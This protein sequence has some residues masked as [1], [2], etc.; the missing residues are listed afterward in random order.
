MHP[1]RLFVIALLAGALVLGGTSLIV[2]A[3]GQYAM[4]GDFKTAESIL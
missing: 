2:A 4:A 3:V 1:R